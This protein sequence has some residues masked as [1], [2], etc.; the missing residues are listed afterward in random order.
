MNALTRL[1]ANATPHNWRGVLLLRTDP[2]DCKQTFVWPDAYVVFGPNG[3]PLKNYRHHLGLT[4]PVVV[5]DL[6]QNFH[7]D[8]LAALADTVQGGGVLII[9]EPVYS[10]LFT[11]MSRQLETLKTY[12]LVHRMTP[13]TTD[14]RDW[15]SPV[16]KTTVST[17]V[18]QPH[19]LS[20]EQIQV[21]QTL[22]HHHY[23]NPGQPA[24]LTAAR[25][26]GK[27]TLLGALVNDILLQSAHYQV[28]ICAPSRAQV[29]SLFAQ[30]TQHNNANLCYLAPDSL[31]KNQPDADLVVVDEAASLPRHLL[32]QIIN[33]YPGV[34]MATTTQGYET[35][36]RGFLLQFQRDLRHRYT[37]F[38]QQTLNNAQRYANGCPLEQWINQGL[39]LEPTEPV[40]EQYTAQPCRYQST[41]GAHLLE[42]Q[43]ADLARLFNLLMDAHYQTSPNDL[44]LLL[45]DPKQHLL[46]QWQG[47]T[48]TGV[49]WL[50]DENIESPQLAMDVVKGKRRP[51]GN[52][53]PQLLA[54]HYVAPELAHFRYR[55]IVRIA[56]L[57]D[58][59]GQ[60]LGSAL[61]H[62]TIRHSGNE[63]IDMLGSSFGHEPRLRQFWQKQGFVA[64]RQGIKPDKTTARPALLMIQ[65]ISSQYQDLVNTWHHYFTFESGTDESGTEQALPDH[66]RLLQKRRL[67]AFAD[68]WLDF[69]AIVASA[70]LLDKAHLRDVPLLQ[71]A[72][73]EDA[74]WSALAATHHLT[75]RKDLFK[76][77]RT[78]CLHLSVKI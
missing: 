58:R 65:A 24:L 33:L 35:C 29:S 12:Q 51:P 42:H 6:R 69:P 30:L 46:I 15:P 19:A 70:R 52:L 20:A 77:L 54:R 4:Y 68:G 47:D 18:P 40:T 5:L 16:A 11:H 28:V 27:S 78:L 61:L 74:D 62:E 10:A 48:L 67:Q 59:Q 41:H 60:G 45:D 31:L 32:E 8:A 53:L 73:A 36:G 37:G 7:A 49:V 43:P 39:L 56:V 66:Y 72:L 13:D 71:A 3:I 34:I 22:L 1:L 23:Q 64:I 38:C 26:R 44:R 57:P 75:G 9:V 2:A 50:S 14:F 55:R 76:T 25:G 63:Q 21:K 17:A